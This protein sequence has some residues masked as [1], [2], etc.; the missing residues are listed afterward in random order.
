MA[1]FVIEQVQQIIF[2][3]QVLIGTPDFVQPIS[4]SFFSDF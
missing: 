4:S 1:L 3:L 2:K